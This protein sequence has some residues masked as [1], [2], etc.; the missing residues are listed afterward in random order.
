MNIKIK[1]NSRTDLIAK[2]FLLPTP[3]LTDKLYNTMVA[4]MSVWN[5]NLILDDNMKN[6]LCEKLGYDTDNKWQILLGDI[7]KLSNIHK[8]ISIASP[9]IIPNYQKKVKRHIKLHP[10]LEKAIQSKFTKIIV[11]HTYR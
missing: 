2:V 8:E 11:E 6:I 1:H 4:I 5:E 9:L 10:D 3:N 7:N